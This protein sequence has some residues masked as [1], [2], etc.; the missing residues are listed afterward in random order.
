M[1]GY[2][3]YYTNNIGLVLVNQIDIKE[4]DNF[5]NLGSI[6]KSEGRADEDITSRISNT[7]ILF[8]IRCAI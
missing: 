8:D 7:K 2:Y 3:Y 1:D 4:I 5:T 6:F